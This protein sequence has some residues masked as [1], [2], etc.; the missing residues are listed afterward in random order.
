MI[1]ENLK[2]Y[3]DFNEPMME[4]SD[5]EL[6]YSEGDDDEIE[7][8]ENGKVISNGNGIEEVRDE[9]EMENEDSVG[10]IIKFEIVF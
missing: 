10:G 8:D 4:V 1:D 5:E 6:C 7:N 3:Y 2:D 9:N